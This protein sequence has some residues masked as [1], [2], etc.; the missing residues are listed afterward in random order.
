VRP[1]LAT[2]TN[3][4][5][6][7]APPPPMMAAPQL[8]QRPVMLAT[9]LATSLPSAAPIHQVRIVNGQ[10]CGKTGSAPLT[11]IVITTPVTA[12]PTRLASPAQALTIPAPL[13]AP[14]P[15][16]PIQISSLISEPK[17][18]AFMVSLGLV[19]HDHLEGERCSDWLHVRKLLQTDVFCS[20]TLNFCPHRDPKQTTG[21]EEEN[22]SQS[23]VQRSCVRA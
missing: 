4:P 3:V 7:P 22:D 5:I 9:K 11:G 21:E 18:L 17:K 2:P 23:S 14:P 16:P 10:P 15:A 19:T 1:R 12:T 6:A 20:E 8:L 13:L